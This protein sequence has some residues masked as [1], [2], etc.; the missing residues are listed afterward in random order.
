MKRI[1]KVILYMRVQK[2]KLEVIHEF[3]KLGIRREVTLNI[4]RE[5]N[6][7]ERKTPSESTPHI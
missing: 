6:S 5:I 4:T 2:I 1:K 7:D 3:M